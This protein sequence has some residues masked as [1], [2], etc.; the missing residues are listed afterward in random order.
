MENNQSIFSNIALYFKNEFQKRVLRKEFYICSYGGSG[1]WML[2]RFLQQYG[3]AYHIHSR[4][5]PKKLKY[6]EGEHFGNKTNMNKKA[7]IIF[8]YS[9]PEHSVRSSNSFSLQH[10]ENIGVEN[11]EQMPRNAETYFSENKDRIR[12]EEFFDNYSNTDRSYSVI[13]VNFHKLWE[14]QVGLFKLL[15][16][17]PDAKLPEKRDPRKGQ[18]ILMPVYQSFRERLEKLD[19]VFISRGKPLG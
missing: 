8:I 4:T 12:F 10:W 17:P 9:I 16:L 6:P 18:Y 1:S 14:N 3:K 19:P 11:H 5:P 2:T 13:F 15:G 7:R